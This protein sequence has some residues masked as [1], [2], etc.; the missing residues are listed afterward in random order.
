M[1]SDVAKNISNGASMYDGQEWFVRT[2]LEILVDVV[3]IWT[4]FPKVHDVNGWSPADGS[5][6][7][8]MKTFGYGA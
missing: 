1:C 3:W 8:R 4:I 6:R 2:S 5:V 7:E